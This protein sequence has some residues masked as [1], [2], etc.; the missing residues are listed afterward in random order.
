MSLKRNKVGYQDQTTYHIQTGQNNH[1]SKREDSENTRKLLLQR[2]L[3][4]MRKSSQD[5]VTIHT[6]DLI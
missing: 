2:G 4:I 3:W 1:K 6:V 5:Q